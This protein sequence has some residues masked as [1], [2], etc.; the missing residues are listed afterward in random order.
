M[1]KI[2]CIVLFFTNLIY[3]QNLKGIV[4][5]SKNEPIIDCMVTLKLNTE[6]ID[7]TKTNENGFFEFEE[8]ELKKYEVEFYKT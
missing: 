7:F 1:N 4:V 2:Y 8:L 6:I 5:N 3:G